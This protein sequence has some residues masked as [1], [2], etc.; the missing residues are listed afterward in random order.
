[1]LMSRNVDCPSPGVR[2]CTIVIEAIHE[3]AISFQFA[4]TYLL[5]YFAVI[6][7][8]SLGSTVYSFC[9][10]VY[11]VSVPGNNVDSS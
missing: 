7:F 6:L 4:L 5:G 2:C 3:N 9:V 10:A 1:M 11:V 8:S